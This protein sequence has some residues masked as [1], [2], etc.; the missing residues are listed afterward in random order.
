MYVNMCVCV[1]MCVN[2]YVCI[3]IFAFSIYTYYK[4]VFQSIATFGRPHR[5]R[6]SLA[7]DLRPRRRW[8]GRMPRFRIKMHC[9]RFGDQLFPLSIAWR[10]Q[11][12]QFSRAVDAP[13]ACARNRWRRPA[14]RTQRPRRS[15]TSPRCPSR[16]GRRE[17]SQ[18]RAA[19]RDTP[20]LRCRERR[21]VPDTAALPPRPGRARAV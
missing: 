5:E 15:R 9:W 1:C 6:Q 21:G 11:A 19:G 4:L 2:I 8:P 12:K 13:E 20:V 18:T 7:I 10:L 14:G 17:C 16:S 3:Y